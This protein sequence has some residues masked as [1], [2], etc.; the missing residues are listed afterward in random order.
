MRFGRKELRRFL[1]ISLL[2]GVATAGSAGGDPVGS[3]SADLT[4]Q[5]V[6]SIRRS[7]QT[8]ADVDPEPWE[9]TV[10]AFNQTACPFIQA[11]ILE[12][13]ARTYADLIKDYAVQDR[14]ARIRLFD[15][16]KMNMAYLQ[17]TGGGNR[18]AGSGLDA[19]I[20]NTLKEY[21]PPAVLSHPE[22]RMVI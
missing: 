14:D 13:M 22:F 18:P 8:L 17:F 16:I 4:P 20:Q 6:E 5:A 19:L 9:N 2:I 15:K 21:L 7:K 11:E 1:W 12:A 10:A 3:C